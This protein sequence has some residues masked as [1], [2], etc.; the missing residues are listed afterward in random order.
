M[1]VYRLER[2]IALM[3]M[4][5]SAVALFFVAGVAAGQ[6]PGVSVSL[7]GNP[8]HAT[9][10]GSSVALTATVRT[11]G[12]GVQKI[13]EG[14]LYERSRIRLTF[15]AQRFWPCPETIVLQPSEV[16][17]NGGTW[18][19]VEETHTYTLTWVP[20]Q[21]RAG[22][23][24]LSVDASYITRPG[25]Q[26]LGSAS[27]NL[28]LVRPIGTATGP[29]TFGVSPPSG[30]TVSFPA[31]VD[32]SA[33]VVADPAYKWRFKF[34]CEGCNPPWSNPMDVLVAYANWQTTAQAPGGYNF[35]VYVDKVQQSGCV[36]VASG[37]RYKLNHA[38]NAQ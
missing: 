22:E 31:V 2:N 30:S 19:V 6:T 23:Y 16:T 32:L 26:F 36:W 12:M 1:A 8:A 4:R 20:P 25:P 3:R 27:I 35:Y 13:G 38:L 11:P 34:Q 29:I 24:T 15:K 5:F 33:S 7:T 28:F 10:V 9:T 18:S 37:Y 14:T 21:V 17:P